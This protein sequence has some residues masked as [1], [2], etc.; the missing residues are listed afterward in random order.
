MCRDTTA[1]AFTAATRPRTRTVASC[2]ARYICWTTS[3]SRT[4]RTTASF[5]N[6]RPPSA[7]ASPCTLLWLRPDR[8][9]L[10]ASPE[11]TLPGVYCRNTENWHRPYEDYK[12]ALLAR[13]RRPR[14]GRLSL[15]SKIRTCPQT[16]AVARGPAAALPARPG[17][18]KT[19]DLHRPCRG[20]SDGL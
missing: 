9:P 7:A 5:P 12:F 4:T 16:P 13:K 3:P 10:P 19:G 8:L 20:R 2:S 15:P 17:P 14:S 1:Y 18:G 6:C 11:E